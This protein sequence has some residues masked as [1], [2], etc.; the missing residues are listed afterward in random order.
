MFPDNG[1][2]VYAGGNNWPLKGGKTTLWE[3]DL[4]NELMLR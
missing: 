3:G 4:D 2:Q 1:G